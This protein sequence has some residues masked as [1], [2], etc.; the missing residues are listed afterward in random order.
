M[1]C[2]CVARMDIVVYGDEASSEMR[3]LQ[4][5]LE[6]KGVAYELHFTSQS[7]VL[8]TMADLSGQTDRPVVVI[9]D[10]VFVGF[11]PVEMESRIS[12]L[13]FD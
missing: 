7:G 5:F 1:G 6:R 2:R 10:H 12:S 4:T 9:N 8:Q 11:D 13:V 3:E